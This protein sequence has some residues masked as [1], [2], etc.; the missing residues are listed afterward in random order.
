MSQLKKLQETLKSLHLGEA[1]DYLPNP[2]ERSKKS[3]D[4]YSSFLLE[5]MSYEQRRR[6]EK[7]IERHL[8]WTTFPYYKTLE[9]FHLIITSSYTQTIEPPYTEL[10]V[11]WCE[12]G[13]KLLNFSL[14]SIHS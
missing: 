3:D 4:T 10:Y 7:K 1:A 5:L 12:R 9:Q 13:E 8:K 2:L 14:C 11:R 6:E